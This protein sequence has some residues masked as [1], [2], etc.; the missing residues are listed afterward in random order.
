MAA[1]AVGRRAVV[2][3]PVDHKDVLDCVF[4]IRFEAP[5]AATRGHAGPADAEVTRPT[6]WRNRARSDMMPR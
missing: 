5:E 4:R 1:V 6:P 3:I 2:H